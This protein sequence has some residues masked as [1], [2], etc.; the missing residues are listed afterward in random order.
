M[1]MARRAYQMA[2]S[3]VLVCRVLAGP[4]PPGDATMIMILHQGHTGTHALCEAMGK[5][6]CVLA[7]CVEHKYSEKD[8]ASFVARAGELG[9]AYAVRMYDYGKGR[10]TGATL[11]EWF[12]AGRIHV[13][14]Q[15]ELAAA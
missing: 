11:R 10:G 9:K 12:A 14:P 5:L 8:M 6:S 7:D 13:S 1:T 3:L 15:P 2:I 4:P